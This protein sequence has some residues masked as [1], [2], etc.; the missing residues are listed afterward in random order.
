MLPVCR[1]SAKSADWSTAVQ[2]VT[3]R[4]GYSAALASFARSFGVRGEHCGVVL[5]GGHDHSGI[6]NIEQPEPHGSP[7]RG[8][9]FVWVRGPVDVAAYVRLTDR[10]QE[11]AVFDD[12]AREILTRVADRYRELAT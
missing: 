8:R 1:L 3:K 9:F 11:L 4:T 12:A 5:D 6:A 10:L 2:I 7:L